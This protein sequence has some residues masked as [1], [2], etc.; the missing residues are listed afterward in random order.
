MP[1][2]RELRLLSPA[3][4]S[5]ND[6]FFSLLLVHDSL[7]GVTAPERR[8]HATSAAA[9]TD[10]LA[11][12][13]RRLD[14][15]FLR[16]PLPER[17]QVD[18]PLARRH[19]LAGERRLPRTSAPLGGRRGVAAALQHLQLRADGSWKERTSAVAVTVR[20]AC[21][22]ARRQNAA[23]Q[24]GRWG[25]RSPPRRGTAGRR[26]SASCCGGLGRGGE[27]GSAR[28]RDRQGTR[29]QEAAAAAAAAPPRERE[30]AWRSKTT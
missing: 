13:A 22:R 14:G 28:E 11:L 1:G 24:S 10:P 23:R 26:S 3:R 12:L 19:L 15:A 6:F 5:G 21:A 29:P 18:P 25:G 20:Q 2:G 27:A 30:R 16:V 9:A 4:P 8:P 17:L 7:G